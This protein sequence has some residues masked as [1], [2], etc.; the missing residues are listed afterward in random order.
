MGLDIGTFL[1][2]YSLVLSGSLLSLNPSYSIG[3]HSDDVENLLDNVG[4]LLGSPQGL[5][6]THNTF[7]VDGSTTRGDA[8]D[9][10]GNGYAL[11]ITY[12]KQLYDLQK[13]AESPDYTLDVIID[14]ALDRF[15]QAVA[16][17]PY[18]YY[19]P[20]S[21]LVLRSGANFFAARLW[22]N[23]TAERPDGYID[24]EMLKSFYGV[25]GP[26][27][28]LVANPGGERIPDNWYRRPDDY[29]VAGVAVDLVNMA[30]KNPRI[31]GI[32]GN[33][34]G[35]NTY[36]GINPSDIV[37]GVL[38]GAGILEGNNLIC[39]AFQ[40]I[41][42]ASPNSLSSIYTTIAKPL[43]VLFDAI[44]KTVLS[45]NCPAFTDMQYGGTDLGKYLL[46]TYP[47]AAKSGHA[48]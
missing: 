12:F 20:F 42:F 41:K 21:G 6:G 18:F 39:F 1:T 27:D 28:N 38:N 22:V 32:G 14:N 31:L 37:G 43:S 19:G 13:D 33:V 48:L 40:T 30:S 2:V 8:Y 34:N 23:C 5:D 45:L 24:K 36:A 29:S 4:G 46:A 10:D 44:D 47:G 9:P 7:E 3:N 26:D 11:N 17:N 16:Y 15:D 25:T 35:V